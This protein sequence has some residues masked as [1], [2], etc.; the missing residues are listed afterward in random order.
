VTTDGKIAF[1]KE[2]R[3]MT[4]QKVSNIARPT[5]QKEVDQPPK[6][7]CSMLREL[8]NRQGLS[9][10]DLAGQLIDASGNYSITREDISRWERGKRIPGPYWRKWLCTV[11]DLPQQDVDLAAA[12]ARR[13]RRP[14]HDHPL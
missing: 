7:L 3:S 9:Q 8:R 4:G 5:G 6:S 11:F 13:T 10:Y 12:V 14:D 1:F 2:A